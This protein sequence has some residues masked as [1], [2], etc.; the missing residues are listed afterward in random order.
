MG[1]DGDL[2]MTSSRNVGEKPERLFFI[3]VN[4]GKLLVVVCLFV[5]SVGPIFGTCHLCIVLGSIRTAHTWGRMWRLVGSILGDR[6]I[7][8]L[9]G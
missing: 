3:L 7:G 4:I 9:E 6:K 8:M 5:Q 1:W 2:G